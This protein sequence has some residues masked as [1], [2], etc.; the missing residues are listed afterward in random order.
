MLAA[1]VSAGDHG[2]A[3][4][5]L[6]ETGFYTLEKR[7]F[8]PQYPLW[9]DGAAKARWIYLPPGTA[10]DARDESAWSFPV[11]TRFWKEFTFNGRKVETRFLWKVSAARWVAASYAWNDD[12]TEAMRAPDD[13][14]PNA[15]ELAPGRA[16][17]IP[18][19]NDCFACHGSKPTRVLGFNP[20]Q[21]S[22]D[23][24]TNAIH[25]EPLTAQM[26]TLETLMKERVIAGAREDLVSNPPRIQTADAQTRAVLGYFAANCASCHDG[27]GEIAALGPTLKY[28][29]LVTDADAVAR[30]IVRQP[31]KWQVP[32]E[33]EGASLLVNTHAP[34]TSA[35]LVRMRSR[36]PSSQM[37]PLGTVIRDERAVDAVAAWIARL[38]ATKSD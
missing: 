30:S 29:D 23:R 32:G 22:P 26:V 10:I 9:S 37:P 18:S 28:H 3:P 2:R 11:G 24:D 16:H 12:G 13:G 21:L 17:A 6:A 7:P 38:A 27:N 5:T 14:V 36:R 34:D 8:S 31:T 33:P 1:G 35:I 15:A 4:A 20:L 25:A 19:S